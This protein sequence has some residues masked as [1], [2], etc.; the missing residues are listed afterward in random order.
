MR[1][2]FSKVRVGILFST[3]FL[4]ALTLA[5]VTSPVGAQEHD[6]DDH[7]GEVLRVIHQ[8]FAAGESSTSDLQDKLNENR[9]EQERIRQLLEQTKQ[10]KSTLQNEIAYQDNQIKLTELKIVETEAEI[11]TLTGQINKLEGALTELSEVFAERAVE[12][13]KLKRLGDSMVVLL[14]SEN[15]T[16]F[17][18]RF[19]YLQ[20]IQQNDRE[21]LLEMQTT[22]TD[23]EDQ[24]A[25][26]E[27]LHDKLEGQKNTLAGQK[28][29]KQNL[30]RVTQSDEKKYQELLASL[31]ADEQAIERAL[32][33]LIARIVAGIATGTNVTKGQIIGQQGNTGNVY[34]R[35][36]SSCPNC[37]SHLHYMVFTCDILKG[38]LSCHTNPQPYLDDGQYNKP[39]NINYMSQGYGAATCSVCGYAFHTGLDLV[40]SHGGPIYAIAD[41]TV[42]YGVD[43]AGGKY[44]LVKHKDD[45]WTA[46]WHLQ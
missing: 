7:D 6:E 41:G 46:Y 26:V 37:G 32:S 34:P 20:R 18:S 36:S 29:Q 5:M 9:K 11:T 45:F 38:G 27:Q 3:L 44:G 25:Q 28:T 16:D 4:V 42:Y 31:R 14:T 8:E 19:N 12:T 43:G 40:G 35:P 10:K 33:S 30:L 21:L 13:Y 17:I 24:R 39:L 23:Y 2:L 22:Q 1:D 15:V